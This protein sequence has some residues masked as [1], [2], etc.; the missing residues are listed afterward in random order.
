VARHSAASGWVWRSKQRLAPEKS[1][2]RKEEGGKESRGARREGREGG[3][4]MEREGSEEA[5]EGLH[6]RAGKGQKKKCTGK[7]RIIFVNIPKI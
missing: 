6:K 5:K 2:E 3:R 4:E 7:F 1:K